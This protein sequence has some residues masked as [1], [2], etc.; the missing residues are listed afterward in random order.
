MTTHTTLPRLYRTVLVAA[1][2][3]LLTV[4]CNK[5]DDRTVGQKVDAAVN[6]A[7]Q[8][9]DEAGSAIKRE[10]EKLKETV[11][12]AAITTS[13]KTAL[14]QDPTLSALA[15]N[16][17]TAAGIVTLHGSAPSVTARE[18]ASELAMAVK[19]VSRVDNQL[20]VKR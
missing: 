6:S 9:T 11:E 5:T 19:G 20:D 12:D 15:I 8:K 7:E 10:S 16:V 3:A 2:A 1:T 14:A 17:D 13:V 18:R 4:G